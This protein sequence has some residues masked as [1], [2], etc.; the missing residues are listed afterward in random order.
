MSLESLMV[1]TQSLGASMDALAAVG[2]ELRLRHECLFAAPRVR[3]SL[4]EVVQ[5]IDLKLLEGVTKNEEHAALRIIEAFFRQ[6]IDLLEHPARVPG[7][8][9]TDPIVLHGQGLA[10]QRFIRAIETLASGKAELKATLDRSGTLLDVGTGAGWLA[11]EAARS[12][13][14]WNVVGIDPWEPALSIARANVAESGLEQRIE[15][16]AQSVEQLED[17]DAFTLA[18]LPGPFLRAEIVPAALERVSR[19]LA[20][21]GWLVFSLFASPPGPLGEAVTKL[22]IV[23]NGGYPWKTRDI[24]DKLRELGFEQI[25]SFSVIGSTLIVGRMASCLRY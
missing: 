24:E 4:E 18:W 10:S 11:I 7:W 22:K 3:L 2:A 1:A 23:R 6:A 13:P 15:L 19:A 9:Y 12:W 16:R 20:P 21:G 14:T 8:S 25:E 5:R 17:K